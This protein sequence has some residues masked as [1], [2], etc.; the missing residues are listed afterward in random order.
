MDGRMRT[1]WLKR[2]AQAEESQSVAE[3][4]KLGIF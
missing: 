4:A 1:T 3:Y 2:M